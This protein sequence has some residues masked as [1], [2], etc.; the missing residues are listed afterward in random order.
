[1]KRVRASDSRRITK[2]LGPYTEIA[3]HKRIKLKNLVVL[4]SH[5]TSP[6]LY[7]YNGDLMTHACRLNVIEI[8]LVNM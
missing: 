6:Y 1:M 3:S 5:K 7:Q 2:A 8:H 4:D